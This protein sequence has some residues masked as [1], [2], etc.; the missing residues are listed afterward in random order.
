MISFNQDTLLEYRGGCRIVGSMQKIIT[1]QRQIHL[2]V[3]RSC[4]QQIVCISGEICPNSG[5]SS[6]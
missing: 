4:I 5:G 3:R 2:I 6:E 1:S